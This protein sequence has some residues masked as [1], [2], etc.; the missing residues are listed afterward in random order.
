MIS[1]R[2]VIPVSLLL[3]LAL[4]PTIIH[5]YLGSE[6][7][8]GRSVQTIPRALAGFSSEPYLRHKDQWVK[9]LYGSEDWIERIYKNDNGEKIRLFAARSYDYKKLYHH[10]ELGLS[11]GSNLNEEGIVM[12]QGD[13]EIPVF[14]LRNNNGHGIVAYALLHE[15]K[16]V[17]EPVSHQ[18]NGAFVQIFSP[19]KAMTLF[20]V[21]D[22]TTPA[23][24]KFIRTP[25]ASLLASAIQSFKA[26]EAAENVN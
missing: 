1:S 5:S 2:Y 21:S 11:H 12:L 23:A 15:G 10:P 22:T 13:P 20:Y 8:D 14:V 25:T 4:L 3:I 7:D 26:N 17:E 19:M 16:F 24:E 6:Y 18:I 9:S